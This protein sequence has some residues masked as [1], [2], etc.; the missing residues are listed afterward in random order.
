MKIVKSCSSIHL[1]LYEVGAVFIRIFVILISLINLAEAE[2]ACLE[3][4]YAF[5]VGSGGIKTT[6]NIVDKCKGRVVEII[7]EHNVYL[8]FEQCMKTVKNGT[9]IDNSCFALTKKAIEEIEKFYDISCKTSKCAGAATE[10][11][12]KAKN[13]KKIMDIFAESGV[14]I[15]I[16]DQKQEGHIGFQTAETHHKAL[17]IP[18]D[19]QV[20][21]DVGGGSFQ[22]A[23]FG[24]DLNI[25]VFNGRYGV[26]S[27]HK[28][29]RKHFK[30]KGLYFSKDEIEKIVSKY[31]ADF[32]KVLDLDK[33]ISNKLSKTELTVFGIGRP[34]S[35]GIRKQTNISEDIIT[36]QILVG[37][38]VEMS[39]LTVEELRKK[40]PLVPGH[41]ENHVQSSLILITCIMKAAGFESVHIIDVK[42]SDYIALDPEFWW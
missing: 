27:F 39:D 42:A 7:G 38:A 21:L 24:E 35:V 15:K 2:D 3:K 26:E 4:R 14:Y 8:K 5:D 19:K 20:V 23:I 10:W 9:Y 1:I 41:F 37:K 13:S 36:P 11:A 12:R 6:G 40:F 30:P 34:L 18:D 28:E 17:A 16:L 31:S 33:I 25:H 29:I 32:K 22:I